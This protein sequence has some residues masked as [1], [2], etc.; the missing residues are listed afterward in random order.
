MTFQI[1]AFFL[2]FSISTTRLLDTFSMSAIGGQGLEG[3][4]QQQ[5]PHIGQPCLVVSLATKCC[6]L[7]EG[8]FSG[9]HRW[10]IC[11][12]FIVPNSL[13]VKQMTTLAARWWLFG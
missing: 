12:Y 2:D 6:A 4:E 13:E 1:Y 10:V 7:S 8:G 11:Q 5:P 3:G 9:D